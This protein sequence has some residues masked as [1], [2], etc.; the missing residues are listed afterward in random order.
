[1][2][3][4]KEITI[5]VPCVPRT[6]IP[7]GLSNAA[8]DSHDIIHPGWENNEYTQFSIVLQTYQMYQLLIADNRLPVSLFSNQ[9][10]SLVLPFYCFNIKWQITR[11]EVNQI[12]TWEDLEFEIKKRY[13][14]AQ[15][16]GVSAS[17]RILF[18]VQYLFV[19]TS[20]QI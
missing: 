8:M 20:R 14:K 11:S 12:E 1:M 18:T 4:C 6:V 17:F 7:R 5:H 16:A 13:I 19:H 2:C 15:K 10:N 3:I 9:M